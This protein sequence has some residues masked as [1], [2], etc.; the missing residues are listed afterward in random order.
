MKI[1]AVAILCSMASTSL[2]AQKNSVE[3][4]LRALEEQVAD[5]K[6]ENAQRD[7]FVPHG[8]IVK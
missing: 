4:R 6:K 1:S 3:A 5:L 7:G 8:I 2:L